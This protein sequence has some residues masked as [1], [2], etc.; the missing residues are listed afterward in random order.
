MILTITTHITATTITIWK[1]EENAYVV[2]D[3]WVVV[4]DMKVV[5]L[6]LL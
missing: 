4:A 3:R 5:V 2:D 6:V 1:E